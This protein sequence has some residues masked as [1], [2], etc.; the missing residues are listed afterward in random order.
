M[1]IIRTAV[2]PVAGYGTRRLPIT[3]AIEKCML[4][5]GD[6]PVVDYVVADCAAA[7]IEHIIFVVSETA[8]QLQTYY[9][10]NRNLEKYLRKQ[11][12]ESELEIIKGTSRGMAISYVTQPENGPYGTAVPIQL[13]ASH[14]M[15]EEAFVVLMGDAFVYRPDGSS[16]LTDALEA[17]RSAKTPHLLL[18]AEVSKEEAQ[19]YGLVQVN[20]DHQLEAFIEKPTAN[21]IPSPALVNLNQFICSTS[22]LEYLEVY[23]AEQ[24]PKANK[25]EYYITDVLQQAATAGQVVTVK[26][27]QGEYLDA[28]NTSAWLKANNQ[29]VKA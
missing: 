2:I 11:G 8:V 17:Y 20:K 25:G 16:E 1:K 18:C 14:L 28:G 6:R 24:P 10:H 23:M 15:G 4:P 7:G 13:V 9:G 26:T 21:S 22:I 19:H 3:K 27:I 12:K 5:I 29:V